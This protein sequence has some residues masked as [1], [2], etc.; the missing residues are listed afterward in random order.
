MRPEPTRDEICR[1]IE[2]HAARK[3]ASLSALSRMLGHRDSYLWR[4]INYGIPDRLTLR[5]RRNL[6]S[7]FAIDEWQLGARPGEPRFIPR[8]LR[9]SATGGRSRR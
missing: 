8:S 3:V 7:F 6:A 2:H 1:T 5:D 9:P 4:F